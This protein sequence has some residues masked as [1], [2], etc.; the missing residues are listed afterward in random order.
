M[1]KKFGKKLRVVVQT[2]YV[3]GGPELFRVAGG[4]GDPPDDQWSKKPSC[5]GFCI[6]NGRNQNC[7]SQAGAC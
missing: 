4:A 3:L 1:T 6:S 5:Q 2:L 7:A